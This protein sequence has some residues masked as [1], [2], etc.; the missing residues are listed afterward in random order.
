MNTRKKRAVVTV[1]EVKAA[2]AKLKKKGKKVTRLTGRKRR[3][4]TE[5]LRAAKETK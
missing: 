3:E 1:A 2:R 5:K 4:L